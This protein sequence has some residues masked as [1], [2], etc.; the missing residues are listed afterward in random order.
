MSSNINETIENV[1]VNE[2]VVTNLNEETRIKLI[3][4]NEEIYVKLGTFESGIEKLVN[5]NED[6]T[7]KIEKVD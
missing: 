7:V 2:E 5:M 1:E 3:V 4:N 6:F